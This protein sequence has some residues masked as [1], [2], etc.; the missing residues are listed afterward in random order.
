[1]NDLM[2]ERYNLGELAPWE[3]ADVEAALAADSSLA[4]RV[5]ELRR[6]DEEILAAMPAALSAAEIQKK[7]ALRKSGGRTPRLRRP[8]MGLCA[9]ALLAALILPAFWFSRQDGE[10]ERAKGNTELAVYLKTGGGDERVQNDTVVREG[11]TVQLA[12]MSAESRYGVIFSL[13]GRS[14]VTLHYPYAAG[15]STRLVSGRRT[16][17]AEAY[18]LDDAP[19]YEIF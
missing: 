17:L 12:Y 5:A 4:G 10:E 9:A 18:T 3:K 8:V 14:A 6:S 19:D 15:Q 7:A 13:D 1:M 16:A 2:L 11:N